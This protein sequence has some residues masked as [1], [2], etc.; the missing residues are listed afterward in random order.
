MGSI[1]PPPTKAPIPQTLRMPTCDCINLACCLTTLACQSFPAGK[2]HTLL[3]RML[4]SSKP[5]QLHKAS[6]P[7]S[8]IY[9]HCAC[10]T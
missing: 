7:P 5:T 1:T 9:R 8:L 6:S 10:T 4:T 2:P 3:L